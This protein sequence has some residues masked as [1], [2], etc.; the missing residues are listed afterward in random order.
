MG[1]IGDMKKE[2][3]EMGYKHN[4]DNPNSATC[5]QSKHK[6]SYITYTNWVHVY[7]MYCI[8]RIIISLYTVTDEQGFFSEDDRFAI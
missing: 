6:T 2:I 8:L 3:M 5:I 7:Y 4:H 1:V